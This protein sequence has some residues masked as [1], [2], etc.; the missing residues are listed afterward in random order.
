MELITIIFLIILALI[1]LV[2]EFMLVPGIS[3][4]GVGSLA[5]FVF[6]VLVGF[7]GF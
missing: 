7:K 6:S 2:V 3:I 1:L 5:F 4:A